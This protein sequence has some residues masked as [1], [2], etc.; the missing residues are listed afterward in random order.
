MM[1]DSFVE[2]VDALGG[3]IIAQKWYYEGTTDV[4]RQ[5]SSIREIGLKRDL[6]E[7][8]TEEMR[9]VTPA[10]LDSAW[11]AENEE[12]MEETEEDEDILETKEI[13]VTS[14][15]AA[16]FPIYNEDISIIAP[17]FRL[18]NIQAQMLGGGYWNDAEQLRLNKSYV[19]NIIFVTDHYVDEFTGEFAKFRDDYRITM[20]TTPQKMDYYGYD[21]VNIVL[22]A[23]SNGG[24]H[25]DS[26][27]NN[28]L[29]ISDYTGKKG[30]VSFQSGSRSNSAINILHYSDGVFKKLY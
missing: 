13:P 17:Q 9:R 29:T 19:E 10:Q 5:M 23:I 2:T 4:G 20:G 16:F 26:F 7:R 1:T 18:E 15:D 24:T 27:V 30:A 8:L 28:L 14:I 11:L 3:Q 12:F 25:R 22:R 6:L 21:T